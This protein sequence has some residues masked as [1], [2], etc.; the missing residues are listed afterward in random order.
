MRLEFEALHESFGLSL[1]PKVHLI[2][3][4]LVDFT[5]ASG[6]KGLGEGSEQGLETSH[7]SFKKIWTNFWV[8]NKMSPMYLKQLKKAVLYYNFLHT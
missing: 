6:G 8:K 1:T 2:F 4:H 7:S 5:K 3:E